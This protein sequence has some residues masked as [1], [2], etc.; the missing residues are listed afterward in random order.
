M[1][2]PVTTRGFTLIEA[3]A[4]VVVLA[5]AAPTLFFTMTDAS[6]AR[7]GAV[8]DTRAITFAEAILGH[9]LADAGS[10]DASFGFAGFA[11][12]AAYETALR[13]RIDPG[14]G[15][16]YAGFGFTWSLTIEPVTATQSGGAWTAAVDMGATNPQYRRVTAAVSWTDQA[17]VAQTLNLE[18]LVADRS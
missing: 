5:I 4:A 9:V 13:A 8:Q 3:M 7:V 16:F 2:R 6:M 14:L 18:V 17:G 10:D 1:I 11:D 15:A 12:A